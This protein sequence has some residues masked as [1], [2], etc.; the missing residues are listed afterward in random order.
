MH[1]A[2]INYTH[3]RQVTLPTRKCTPMIK[4]MIQDQQITIN[5]FQVHTSYLDHFSCNDQ[6]Q[7]FHVTKHVSNS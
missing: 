7:H 1:N 3:S 6:Q 4:L 2:I 5:R